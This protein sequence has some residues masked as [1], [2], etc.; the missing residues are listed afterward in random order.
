MPKISVL[1]SVYK[2][3]VEWIELAIDSILNQTF[4][5]FE[6]IIVNDKPD[7]EENKLLLNKYATR[8]SRI[9]VITNDTNIGL[10]KSLNKGLQIAKG[11]YIARMDADDISM[12]DRF[13]KQVKFLDNHSEVGVCG[14]AIEYFGGLYRIKR[15]PITTEQTFLFLETCFAHPSTM[16][17]K[18]S[19]EREKFYNESYKVS[20]D[21]ELWTYLY[22]KGVKFY[23]FEEVLL[24][25][26]FSA[27]QITAKVGREQV[28]ASQLI[29]RKAFND[30]AK[31]HGY[32][33][34][35]KSCGVTHDVV[36]YV[37]TKFILPQEIKSRLLLYLLC[38][39]QKNKIKTLFIICLG[40][41]TI[42]DFLRVIKYHYLHIPYLK[43]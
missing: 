36:E 25:Y 15:Y 1:M 24:R 41:M 37:V 9:V 32:K 31:M 38:S 27:Q 11:E 5:D 4:K 23:N 35:L 29:R 8:D 16:I 7:R 22:A 14:S 21:Y 20:Q 34:E 39:M 2:E 17:R 28:K 33:V 10:T 18:S 40:K 30:Y 6:F 42:V 19:V 13:E 12:P 43:Y 3:P 26:R